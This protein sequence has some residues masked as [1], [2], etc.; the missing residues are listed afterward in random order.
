MCRPIGTFHPSDQ[1]D[2]LP[3]GHR[4]W[5]PPFQLRRFNQQAFVIGEAYFLFLLASMWK[6]NGAGI[7][8]DISRAHGSRARTEHQG[9]RTKKSRDRSS[10]PM[11]SFDPESSHTW[12]RRSFWVLQFCEQI[13]SFS[14]SYWFEVGVLSPAEARIISNTVTGSWVW[15]K[16]AGNP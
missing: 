11:K 8:V 5:I 4:T 15:G 9:N 7:V 16:V 3:D 1:R 6:D 13:N 10:S 12:S 2:W 14:F